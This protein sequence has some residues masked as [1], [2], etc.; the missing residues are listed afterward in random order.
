MTTIKF[1]YIINI[2]SKRDINN[3]KEFNRIMTTLPW[4]LSAEDRLKQR[5]INECVMP[6]VTS[7]LLVSFRKEADKTSDVAKNVDVDIEGG[8]HS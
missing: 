5:E 6:Y 1:F 7:L 3:E 8:G 4:D 2:H